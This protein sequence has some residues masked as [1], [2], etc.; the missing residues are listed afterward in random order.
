MID[1]WLEGGICGVNDRQSRMKKGNP[2]SLVASLTIWPA[3]M[4]RT[5][6][7]ICI[8]ELFL[9]VTTQ[10]YDSDKSAHYGL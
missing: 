1:H 7:A 2:R 9:D 6:Y 8:G 5:K 10:G 4:Q 3:M